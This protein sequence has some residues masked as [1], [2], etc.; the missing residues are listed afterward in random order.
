MQHVVTEMFLKCRRQL[1]LVLNKEEEKKWFVICEHLCEFH[2]LKT[3]VNNINNNFVILKICYFISFVLLYY[4][5][6]FVNMTSLSWCCQKRTK[7]AV[8]L[9]KRCFIKVLHQKMLLETLIRI[10]FLS[11]T[12]LNFLQDRLENVSFVKYRERIYRDNLS[13]VCLIGKVDVGSLATR[14]QL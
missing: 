4:F 6:Q 3:T 12:P 11:S 8:V 2:I 14:L 1:K 7:E 13:C 9:I 10:F 5:Q